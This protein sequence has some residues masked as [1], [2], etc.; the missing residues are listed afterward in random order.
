LGT[1]DGHGELVGLIVESTGE[2]SGGLLSVWKKAF[3]KD[4]EITSFAERVKSSSLYGD[5]LCLASSEGDK[6][7]LS[8]SACQKTKLDAL[9]G[10]LI[11]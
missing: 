8:K 9:E 3:S 10:D 2:L 6:I 11:A 1:V 5:L 4:V 7:S